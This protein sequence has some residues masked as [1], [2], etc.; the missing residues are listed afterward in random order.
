MKTA[1]KL[2]GW[3]VVL[4]I[5]LAVFQGADK[6]TQWGIGIIA[7]S[8]WLIYELEK[9]VKQRHDR[10]EAILQRIEDKLDQ[11]LSHPLNTRYICDGIE[12]MVDE[13]NARNHSDDDGGLVAALSRSK[14]IR[15]SR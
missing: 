4:L 1:L 3:L 8:G 5:V 10:Q 15:H 12:A 14:A 2:V 7:V 6:L 11:I 9:T 13:C